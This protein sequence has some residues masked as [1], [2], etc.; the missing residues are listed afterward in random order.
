MSSVQTEWERVS[1]HTRWGRYISSI[2]VASIEL[3]NR[4]VGPAGTALDLGCGPGRWSAHLATFGW[5]VVCADINA[6]E[7]GR[8]RQ[9]LPG[10]ECV[11][12]NRGARTLPFE[13]R[14]ARLV[15]VFEV[16][17]LTQAQWFPAEAARVLA[18]G[19][20]LVCTF[21]NPLSWRGAAVRLRSALSAARRSRTWGTYEGPTYRR[22]RAALRTNGLVVVNEQ[23]AC[24]APL[25][26]ASDSLLVGA[27]SKLERV[28]GL[29]RLPSLSPT[30]AVVGLKR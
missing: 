27:F 11:L 20:A 18:P 6:G 21:H 10:A 19:G 4:L 26:S 5:D 16:P 12:L 1:A 28:S 13:D 3:A 30:I 15:L 23:G 24:W 29:R 22:F 9:R 2:Q 8:C 25:T 14:S 7:L 17:P